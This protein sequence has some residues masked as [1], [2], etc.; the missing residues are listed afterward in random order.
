MGLNIELLESSFNAIAPKADE[1]ADKFYDRL[2]REHPAVKPLFAG[3]DMASQKKQLVAMLA[4][5]VE[6]L[7]KPEQLAEAVKALGIR[8]I[9]YGAQREHYPVVG[10]NLLATLADVAGDLWNDELENAWAEAY[11][12]I[13]GMIYDALDE[14]EGLRAAG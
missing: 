8:H 5:V 11:A 10:Q 3:T 12:A 7:R 14:Q 2:F 9:S 6:N 4:L 13:Q 1:L